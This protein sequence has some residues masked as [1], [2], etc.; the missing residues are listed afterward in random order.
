MIFVHGSKIFILLKNK[1]ERKTSIYKK[2]IKSILIFNRP[3]ELAYLFQL[4]VYFLANFGFMCK[5]L[6]IKLK[7]C[8][9]YLKFLNLFP[10]SHFIH[11]MPKLLFDIFFSYQETSIFFLQN[12]TFCCSFLYLFQI[13]F[14]FSS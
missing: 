2:K 9:V 4:F 5:L 12:I 14:F 13:S 8:F 3:L 11:K 7:Y 6:Q 10:C 1:K